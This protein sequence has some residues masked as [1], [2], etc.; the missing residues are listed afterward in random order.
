M[1]SY[2]K[3]TMLTVKITGNILGGVIES[4]AYIEYI[5]DVLFFY[6]TIPVEICK[7]CDFRTV[8]IIKWI[9]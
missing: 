9:D 5:E 4:L 6:V 1:W 7:W 3:G 2:T 8:F